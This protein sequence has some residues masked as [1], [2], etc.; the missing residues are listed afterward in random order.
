MNAKLTRTTFEQVLLSNSGDMGK[1][2]DSLLEMT[3]T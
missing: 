3:A 2:I 1:T